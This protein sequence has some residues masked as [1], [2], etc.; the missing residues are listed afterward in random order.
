MD[1]IAFSTDKRGQRRR[2]PARQ[3][4]TPVESIWRLAFWTWLAI[5]SADQVARAGTLVQFNFNV[6]TGVDNAGS[7]LVDLFDD[8]TPATVTNFLNYVNSGEYQNYGDP[9]LAIGIHCPRRRIR[10]FLPA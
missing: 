3:A 5:F 8:L 2:W 7:V 1:M 6:P 10:S 9:S 4:R